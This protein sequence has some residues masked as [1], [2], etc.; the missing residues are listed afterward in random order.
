M[1]SM[2]STGI[3]YTDEEPIDADQLEYYY[4]LIQRSMQGQADVTTSLT[5]AGVRNGVVN[6]HDYMFLPRGVAGDA[7]T[8]AQKAFE[9]IADEGYGRFFNVY[10]M[11]GAGDLVRFTE[12]M[13]L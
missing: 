8:A 11:D 2:Q 6:G 7:R 5:Q 3:T 1:S 4:Q 12:D 10:F 9:T 13:I